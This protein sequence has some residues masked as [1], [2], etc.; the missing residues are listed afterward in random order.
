MRRIALLALFAGGAGSVG[1]TAFT[2]RNNRSLMLVSLFV[3]WVL[4]P[5]AALAWAWMRVPRWLTA[6]RSAVFPLTLALAVGAVAIYGYV[7]LGPPR[8]QIAFTFLVVP[9]ASWLLLAVVV[10]LATWISRSS[11]SG[12]T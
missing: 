3:F 8:P 2:G 9:A 11:Q 4:S 5:Y 7:A 10:A 12:N 6:T 1:F